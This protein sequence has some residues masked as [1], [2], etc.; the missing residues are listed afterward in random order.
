MKSSAVLLLISITFVAVD[1]LPYFVLSEK[2]AK[3][4]S[5]S[6]PRNTQISL[7]YHFPDIVVMAED[8]E[9]P[10]D[11]KEVAAEDGRMDQDELSRRYNERYKRKM[12]MMAKMGR[13]M[14]DVSIA[15][16][17]KFDSET[18]TRNRRHRDNEDAERGTQRIREIIQEKRGTLTF[19]SSPRDDAPVEICIQCM[20]ATPNTPARFSL[21]VDMEPYVD[22]AI[23][24]A[25]HMEDIHQTVSS[26]EKEL[27]SLERKLGMILNLAEWSK[28]QEITVHSRSIA[29]S[30]ATAYWPMIHI[31][32]LVIASYIQASHVARFF[33]KHRIL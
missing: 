32:V 19:I 18:N 23:E 14:N 3:C 33:K 15:M 1:G 2:V 17:Q 30:R 16:F 10:H 7:N 24:A 21:K 22:P 26:I 20:T 9:D 8:M 12:E 28:Q 25:R 6:P 11:A 5:I 13:K 29:I 27:Q 31:A 4:I